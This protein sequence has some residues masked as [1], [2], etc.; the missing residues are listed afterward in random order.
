MFLFRS[1]PIRLLMRLMVMMQC[2]ATTAITV[3][4]TENGKI[5]MYATWGDPSR[6]NPDDEF[7]LR[8]HSTIASTFSFVGNRNIF[9]ARVDEAEFYLSDSSRVLIV[10]LPNGHSVASSLLWNSNL[11]ELSRC[12]GR[13]TKIHHWLAVTPL[14]L[15]PWQP[16]SFQ[17]LR[18]RSLM[19]IK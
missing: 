14:I 13:I 7:N 19:E 16:D 15:I 9:W 18:Y 12:S 6:R 2:K 8:D 5:N 11:K 4:C 1:T 10:T 3:E 17:V